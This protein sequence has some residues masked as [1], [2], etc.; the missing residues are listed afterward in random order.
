L[1]LV[2][3][4]TINYLIQLFKRHENRSENVKASSSSLSK[5]NNFVLSISA[6]GKL[7]ST[8]Q[9]KIKVIICGYLSVR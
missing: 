1:V 8:H 9:I 2:D 4:R 5:L 3:L 7:I 6:S